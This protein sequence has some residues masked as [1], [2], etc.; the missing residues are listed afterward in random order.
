MTKEEVVQEIKNGIVDCMSLIDT[1]DIDGC[2]DRMLNLC[3]KLDANNLFDLTKKI[4]DKF[5]VRVQKLNNLVDYIE[6]TARYT[7]DAEDAGSDSTEALANYIDHIAE[8]EALDEMDRC[9]I[10]TKITKDKH[11][12]CYAVQII[13]RGLFKSIGVVR[14]EVSKGQKLILKNVLTWQTKD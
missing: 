2:T 7:E 12:T 13:A 8:V 14:K 6:K 9:Y 11:V 4:T 10:L 5:D 3:Y 1:E